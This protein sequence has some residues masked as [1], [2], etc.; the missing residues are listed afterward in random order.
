MIQLKKFIDKVS[1]ADSKKQ[2]TV[3]LS[4]DDARF[5]RDEISKLLMDLHELKKEVPESTIEVVVS[6]GTFK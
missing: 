3:V 2:T 5:L 6:G 4:M 1:V